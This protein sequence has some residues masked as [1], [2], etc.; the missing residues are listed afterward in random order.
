M[1]TFF[2]WAALMV[3]PAIFAQSAFCDPQGKVAIFSNYDGGAL[4][5]NVDQDI[6]GLHIGIV[7]YEFAVIN[8]TGPYA[9][10][11][12][13]VQWAGFN[14]TNDHCGTG[15]ITQSTV[16]GG[17][18]SG[19]SEIVVIPPATLPNPNGNANIICAYSCDIDSEQGGC[20]TVDQVVDYFMDQWD[21]TL[22]FHLTQYG[23]WNGTYAISDGGN[24]C[25]GQ[26]ASNVAEVDGPPAWSIHPVPADDVLITNRPGRF[27]VLDMQR[28]VLARVSTP[29]STLAV[30]AFPPGA[31]QLRSM[32]D[33]QCRRFL[34][35]R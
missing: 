8:I 10:D 15:A 25:I 1:R 34:V 33:G 32:D 35:R 12:V 14:G 26:V 18:T 23:C 9:A 30:A 13:E 28:R 20:N 21:G 3:Q 6:P 22:L 27:E 7:S 2:S 29:G 31:Y 24:C 17:V 11:V 4:T 19:A 5:I 16:I